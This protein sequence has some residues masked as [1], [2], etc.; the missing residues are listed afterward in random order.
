M[1]RYLRRLGI[2]VIHIPAK[3]T[4]LLQVCD[5]R[6]FK[7]LK[8]RVRVQ[9]AS[10]RCKDARGRLRAGDW[11]ASCG[12]AIREI[13]V[14]RCWEDAF[15]RMGL[16]AT[17][18]A[19]GGRAKRT[20]RPSWVQ[21]RLPSRAEFG[22]VGNRSPE[23]EGLGAFHESVLRQFL[24]VHDLLP[25]A[26]PR[27]GAIVPIPDIGP[28]TKRFRISE[29]VGMDW[30]EAVDRELE[31]IRPGDLHRPHGRADAVQRTLPARGIV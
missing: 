8:T 16:G 15:E 12:T 29:A 11:A 5:V 24:T 18:D 7:E 19:V 26:A 4:S 14:D 17:I 2:L 30:D 13:I 28:A 3:L 31:R 21:P 20:V 9:K 22:R 23:T 6:V 25:D 10:I 1:T 27:T